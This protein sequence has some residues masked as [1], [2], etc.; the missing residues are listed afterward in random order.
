[1]SA[2]KL[3]MY[4][5]L[6]RHLIRCNSYPGRA[7][8]SVLDLRKF[9]HFPP[10]S[11]HH[12]GAG[13]GGGGGGGGMGGGGGRV[14]P[15]YYPPHPPSPPKKKLWIRHWKYKNE[16]ISCNVRTKP[17]GF[18][19]WTDTKFSRNSEKFAKI[20]KRA[21]VMNCIFNKFVGV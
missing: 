15:Y 2:L 9:Q 18:I 20:A 6:L 11:S 21:S 5:L 1:M 4:T 3:Y 19:P 10:F 17:E 13:G 12:G 16:S 7:V 8:S 14:F